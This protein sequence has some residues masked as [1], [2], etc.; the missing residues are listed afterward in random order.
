MENKRNAPFPL[1]GSVRHG[2]PLLSSVSTIKGCGWYQKNWSVSSY[3][4]APF[5]LGYQHMD[6]ALRGRSYAHSSLLTVSRQKAVLKWRPRLSLFHFSNNLYFSGWK[7]YSI[8]SSYVCIQFIHI[9]P[10]CNVLRSCQIC[11]EP[12]LVRRHQLVISLQQAEPCVVTR[13]ENEIKRWL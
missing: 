9:T 13:R 8:G 2:T 4:L 3:I 7:C 6:P 1:N 5:L 12:Q 11:E 10:V